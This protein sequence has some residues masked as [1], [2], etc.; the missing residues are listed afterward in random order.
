F[1]RDPVPCA[2][3]GQSLL[4]AACPPEEA[5][6]SADYYERS[7]GPTNEVLS[8]VAR[9]RP[10]VVT[11][12][13]G[14]SLCKTGTCQDRLDGEFLYRDGNHIRRNLALQT[15]RDYAG[16]VGLTTLLRRLENAAAPPGAQ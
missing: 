5:H 8:A 14:A 2:L 9:A 1:L 10:N 16:L 15:R 12:F 11:L 3:R 13:P 7:V 4:R 6:V